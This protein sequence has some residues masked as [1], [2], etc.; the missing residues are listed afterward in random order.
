MSKLKR[1]LSISAGLSLLILLFVGNLL[2]ILTDKQEDAKQYYMPAGNVGID[3]MVDNGSEDPIEIQPNA[4]TPLSIGVTNTGTKDCY[5]F[6][7][8]V[9]PELSGHPILSISPAGNWMKIEDGE[10]QVYQYVVDGTGRALDSG[11]TTPEFVS[12][13][14]FYDFEELVDFTGGV[15]VV[16]YAVQTDG[17]SP[18]ASASDIWST[19]IQAVGN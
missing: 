1:I 14:R 2:G 5:V 12:E 9:N 10:N 7:K 13:A 8:L 11:M 19:T 15:Q 18:E 16:A 17:F 4:V 6:V 3:L